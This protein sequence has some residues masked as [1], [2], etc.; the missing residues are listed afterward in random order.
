MGVETKLPTLFMASFQVAPVHSYR[1]FE[2]DFDISSYE[3][4]DPAFAPG[5]RAVASLPDF[6]ITCRA[7]FI[8][9]GAPSGFLL[10]G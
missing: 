4:D 2:K 8:L 5:Y 9:M 7:K 3:D 10:G 1:S 6:L